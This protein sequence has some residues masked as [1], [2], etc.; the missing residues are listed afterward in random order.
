MDPE[1]E[2]QHTPSQSPERCCLPPLPATLASICN[3]HGLC[4]TAQARRYD[5]KYPYTSLPSATHNGI[6]CNLDETMPGE[7]STPHTRLAPH[8]EQFTRCLDPRHCDLCGTWQYMITC[9]QTS[10]STQLPGRT[11]PSVPIAGKPT[12]YHTN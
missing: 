8:L 4:T 6:R 10:V 3:G 11:P 1:V 2:P 12:P 5:Q 7:N 9:L